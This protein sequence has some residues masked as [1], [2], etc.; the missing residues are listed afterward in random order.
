MRLVRDHSTGAAAVR[1]ACFAC[2][3]WHLLSEMVADLD[4][5]AFR[6]Y[7]CRGHVPPGAVAPC[8]RDGCTRCAG[9]E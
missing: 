5:P 1:I 3:A 8:G 9:R 4:G 7:Y 2:G 6:A